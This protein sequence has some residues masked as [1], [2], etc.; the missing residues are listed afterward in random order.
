MIQEEELRRGDIWVPSSCY[1][2]YGN[3]KQSFRKCGLGTRFS[4]VCWPSSRHTA[5]SSTGLAGSYNVPQSL[6]WSRGSV[7]EYN[8]HMLKLIQVITNIGVFV[9]SGRLGSSY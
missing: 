4:G 8:S 9:D 6:L 2:C 7:S 3:P 1:D 5:G